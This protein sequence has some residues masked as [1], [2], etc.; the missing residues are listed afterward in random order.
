MAFAEINFFPSS[1]QAE[2]EKVF[3]FDYS[4][5]TEKLEYSG[6]TK[7]TP[8]VKKETSSKLSNNTNDYIIKHTLKKM[9]SR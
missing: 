4:E 9:M 1:K 2:S 8:L 7:S 5:L 3:P 6:D